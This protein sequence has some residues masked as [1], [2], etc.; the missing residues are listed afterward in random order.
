MIKIV[1]ATKNAAKIAEIRAIMQ[2][3][4][5]CLLSGG[6]WAAWPEVEETGRSFMENAELKAKAVADFYG[7]PALADDSGL[8]C[9]ALD[10]APGIF[11]AR[12]AGPDA[13][14]EANVG[15][16]LADLLTKEEKGEGSR[17]AR[18]VAAVVL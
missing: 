17:R 12:Y 4:E 11:S 14:D 2:G 6:E 5:I 13:T 15:K 1:V 10:G 7:L 18:F 16:L 3:Q 9:D 8:E